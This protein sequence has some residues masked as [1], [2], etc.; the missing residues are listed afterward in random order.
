MIKLMIFDHDMTIVDSSY[1]IMAGFNA[2]ADEVG[3][4]RVDHD[5][6]MRCIPP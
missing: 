2:V 1:A 3:R 5:L 6:V 4:P